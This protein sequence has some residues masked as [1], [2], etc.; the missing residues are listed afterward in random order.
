MLWSLVFHKATGRDIF[1]RNF[2][3]KMRFDNK[4][5]QVKHLV[6]LNITLVRITL[7]MKL[8]FD[9]KLGEV[10]S[11]CLHTPIRFNI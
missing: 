11:V 3:N 4:R 10:T 5:M 6:G 9:G 7:V 2:D 1:V 8:L